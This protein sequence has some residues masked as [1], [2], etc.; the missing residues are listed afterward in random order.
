MEQDEL[1]ARALNKVQELRAHVEEID[2]AKA[3][4]NMVE[5][6][7]DRV[8]LSTNS[9]VSCGVFMYKNGN[10]EHFCLLK[11]EESIG[12]MHTIMCKEAKHRRMVLRKLLTDLPLDGGSVEVSAANEK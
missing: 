11:S 12:E 6:F 8:D 10:R 9:D 7:C 5:D 3:C 2:K 4:L 1:K